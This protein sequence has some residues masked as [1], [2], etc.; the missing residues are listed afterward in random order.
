MNLLG[1]IQNRV[2]PFLSNL[3]HTHRYAIKVFFISCFWLE[4]CI[5]MKCKRPCTIMHTRNAHSYKIDERHN[6]HFMYD[7]WSIWVLKDVWSCMLKVLVGCHVC[8]CMRK[9]TTIHDIWI[10]DKNISNNHETWY[11][12]LNCLYD[13]AWKVHGCECYY[14]AKIKKKRWNRWLRFFFFMLCF[15]N[16]IKCVWKDFYETRDRLRGVWSR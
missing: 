3:C 13:H 1:S 9:C 8:L 14:L 5:F 16:Q 2:Y 10:V 15:Q 6:S 11:S 7:A 12:P 4:L